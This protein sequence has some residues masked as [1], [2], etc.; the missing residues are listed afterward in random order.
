[1]IEYCPS[2][3]KKRENASWLLPQRGGEGG[4]K[5]NDR[6]RLGPKE[7]AR[8]RGR[9]EKDFNVHLSAY[10][11]TIKDEE[12]K[13]GRGRSFCI[14]VLDAMGRISST[15]S[16]SRGKGKNEQLLLLTPFP[17]RMGE[18]GERE[19]GGGSSIS[20]IAADVGTGGLQYKKEG[21]GGKRKAPQRS[22]SFSLSTHRSRKGRGGSKRIGTRVYPYSTTWREV[23]ASGRGG[24]GVRGRH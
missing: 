4:G 10:L 18:E 6:N 5:G 16:P 9:E 13:K 7:R 2:K 17:S 23:G 11:R 22:L 19:G 3:G 8:L 14:H 21:G 24:N 12:R 20:S 1:M 15:E